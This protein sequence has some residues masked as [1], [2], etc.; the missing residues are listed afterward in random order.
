M[1]LQKKVSFLVIVV[2]GNCVSLTGRPISN[3]NSSF[4]GISHCSISHIHICLEYC[5]D[6]DAIENH[7]HPLLYVIVYR[8]QEF[9]FLYFHFVFRNKR[10]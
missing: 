2:F 3:F 8:S 4:F 10:L 1:N 5:I 6:I 7:E 9:I